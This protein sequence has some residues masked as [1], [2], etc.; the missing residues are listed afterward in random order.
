MLP[1]PL[2]VASATNL[3]DIPASYAD[4][5]EDLATNIAAIPGKMKAPD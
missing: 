1:A 2:W 5:G 4:D 3:C